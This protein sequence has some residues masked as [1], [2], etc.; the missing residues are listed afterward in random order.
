MTTIRLK[1][2]A[3]V[4]GL[5]A[6]AAVAWGVF[7]GSPDIFHHPAGLM[8]NNNMLIVLG[9]AAGVAFGLGIARLTNFTV[10]RFRWA[11]VLHIEFRGLFGPLRN[12][13][14]LAFAAFS[15]IA[16]EMFFRGALQSQLGIVPASLIFGVLH[17]APNKKFIPWPFQAAGMGFAFG[18]LFW[19]SGNLAAPVLAHFTIN[20]QN[21]H[22]INSYD[23]SLQLPRSFASGLDSNRR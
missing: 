11:R 14:I 5:M 23:P 18:L 9:G 7:K 6:A 8:G 1:A 2:A 3:L 15:A 19:M 21:L 16:E 12:K 22:F 10:Y 20:Y 13:D 4:Y 17:I